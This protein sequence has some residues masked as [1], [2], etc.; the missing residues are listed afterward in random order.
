MLFALTRIYS[1]GT[2]KISGF[3]KDAT[4][5]EPLLGA[6]VF[7][8]GSS[9]GAASDLKG[10][11]LINSVPVGSHT[12][13]V[14]YIGYTDREISIK[15]TKNRTLN[16][17]IELN[18]KV[19]K[20]EE[21]VVT[22]QAEGQMHA[23]NRQLSS[24]SI[25][26]VVSAKQIQEIPDANAAEAIGRLPGISLLRSGG[27]GSKVVIRGL[28]PQF[29]KVQVEGVSM[30]ST[31]D[32]QNGGERSSDLSMISPYM[33]EGI[34]VTKAA[35]PDKE[36][37]AIGG[38]VN[39][40][41]REAPEEFHFD[42]LAQSS[43]NGLKSEF[44][45]YKFVLN[46]SNRFFNSKLGI[47]AQIDIERRNRSSYELFVNYDPGKTFDASKKEVILTA[48]N[49][50]DITRILNR[51]GGTLVL[52]YN[53]PDGLIKLNSFASGI[54]KNITNRFESHNIASQVHGYSLEDF[55]NDLIVLNNSLTFEH[56]LFGGRFNAGISYTYSENKSP[57]R[58]QFNGSEIGAYKDAI[59]NFNGDPVEVPNYA[60]NDF[61]NIL[62]N[63]MFVSETYSL[64]NEVG[65]KFDYKYNFNIENFANITVKTGYKFKQK[66]KEFDRN[67]DRVDFVFNSINNDI[68]LN[69]Y[70]WMQETVPLGTRKMPFILFN[71]PDYDGSDFLNGE[72]TITNMPKIDLMNDIASL[73]KNTSPFYHTNYTESQKNDYHGS[74]YYN[75]GYLMANIKFGQSLTFIPG[76]RYEKNRTVYTGTRGSVV[77]WK[78]RYPH[79]DTTTTRINEFLLP[80]VHLKYKPLEWFD[81]RLAYT[82]TISRPNYNDI[83]PFWFLGDRYIRWN[84]P[85]LKPAHSQNYDIYASFYTNE[86]GLFTVGYFQKKIFDMIFW[87]G[88]N[89]VRDAVKEYGLPATED[90]NILGTMVNNPFAVKLNG[91]EVEW[92][93]NFWYLPGILKGL[94][95]SINYTY[96]F[97]E[98]KYPKT[99]IKKQILPVFKVTV[100]DT[101]YVDRL[102]NQPSNVFNVT[103]GYDYK[104][105]STRVSLL[106]QDDIF[107]RTHFFERYRGI[108]SEFY[109]L[110][111]SLR[112]KLP[113]DGLEFIGNLT[114]IT[115]TIEE[116]INVG[117]GYPLRKQQYGMTVDL[118]LRYQF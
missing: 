84:N 103:L 44:G 36:A 20:G 99:F 15:V 83:I 31:G 37:D 60:K 98:A 81:L 14:S 111:I 79:Y 56:N 86:I 58:A 29:T 27:E 54:A 1:Q 94:V 46:G 64:E 100:N 68:I 70:P 118:G 34:E 105:F 33:L 2:G 59:N 62:L 117:S 30:S 47:F 113:I 104:G 4:T 16:L 85:Y 110:D 6:N 39:F 97:S 55:T 52:D 66:Y 114:N 102:I 23:I 43:Y 71:D 93:T 69:A 96:T 8:K 90:G 53:L 51:Y 101:F 78:D 57:L 24:Q 92:K 112:Q 72:Y 91:L 82:E 17:D 10:Y 80:M 75:A 32:G 87:S 95:L 73:L 74:E 7:I 116:D 77:Q 22:G 13:K 5:G 21:V 76:V 38:T 11:F 25:K 35:L 89:Y 19:V 28:S 106:F 88:N 9:I 61:N 48:V 107:K 3:V 49:L 63:N 41:L 40:L 67:Q 45:D 108:S 109:K 26:N 12:L 115:D 65:A 42:V 50:K 18:F